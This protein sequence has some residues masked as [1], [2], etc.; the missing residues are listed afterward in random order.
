MRHIF[1]DSLLT[2]TFTES[3]PISFFLD[4]DMLQHLMLL[5]SKDVQLVNLAGWYRTEH[6]NPCTSPQFKQDIRCLNVWIYALPLRCV[7]GI[8]GLGVQ[9]MPKASVRLTE[10]IRNVIWTRKS[11]TCFVLKTVWMVLGRTSESLFLFRN[12]G[13]VYMCI[14][15]ET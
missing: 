4:W 12:S 11:L 5:S 1:I 15:G 13:K 9:G 14:V 3:Y 8:L 7:F 2:V 6:F 10:T